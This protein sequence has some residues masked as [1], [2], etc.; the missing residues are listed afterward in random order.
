MLDASG[1]ILI[2]RG[3]CP[4][5]AADHPRSTSDLRM[6]S[7]RLS[8]L[9]S[10]S[11]ISLS[12]TKKA[13]HLL[14]SRQRLVQRAALSSALRSRRNHIKPMSY[15]LHEP[16]V[17]DTCASRRPWVFAARK[18]ACLWIHRQPILPIILIAMPRLEDEGSP[19]AWCT[20]A[21]TASVAHSRPGDQQAQ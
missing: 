2:V 17:A 18:T 19:K 11:R 14:A 13:K 20:C 21:S 12:N 3:L 16:M 10:A 5:A 6:N 8:A 9:G 7:T 1:W 4:I 15:F